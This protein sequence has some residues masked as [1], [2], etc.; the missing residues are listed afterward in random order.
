LGKRREYC[1]VNNPYSPDDP[2]FDETVLAELVGT[3]DARSLASYYEI[4]VNQASP[5]LAVFASGI[6][7]QKFREIEALAHKL[8]SSAHSVGARPLGRILEQ[9]EMECRSGN[10]D[11]LDYLVPEA[12]RLTA[13][14]LTQIKA[15]KV[16]L[17]G[18]GPANPKRPD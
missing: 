8:K 1:D 4:F 18:L 17:E 16:T 11:A 2:V 6:E 10:L 9:V 15:F 12:L 3:L 7:Q 14:T 5:I 13:Q